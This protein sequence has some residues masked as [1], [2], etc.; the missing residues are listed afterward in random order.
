[1]SNTMLSCDLRDGVGSNTCHKIR[2]KGHVPGVIYGH[3]ISSYPLEFDSRDV[4]KIIREYGE[5]AIVNVSVNGNS[6]PAMIK[7]I[8]RNIV[9]NEIIH[10]DLQQ[11]NATEKIH[12][13]IPILINGKD[14]VDNRGILQKQIEKIEVECYPNNM[15]RFVSI[16]VSDLEIGDLLRVSDVEFGDELSVLND[17]EEII[18]SLSTIKEEQM[19]DIGDTDNEDLIQE[20][21]QPKLVGNE[22]KDEEVL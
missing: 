1:M 11:V 10:V 18:V 2:N 21:E 7:E 14:K 5:N 22:N 8:Q 6:Y 15:P 4:N 3:N 9:T 17:P 12:T 19:D 16:D 20:K 13:A